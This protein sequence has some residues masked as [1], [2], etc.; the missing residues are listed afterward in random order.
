[1][2]LVKIILICFIIMANAFQLNAVANKKENSSKA[3]NEYILL[4]IMT[5]GDDSSKAALFRPGSICV[6]LSGNIFVLDSGNRRVVKFSPQ[7][8]FLQEFGRIGQGPGEFQEPWAMDLDLN[9]GLLYISDIISRRVE[10]YNIFGKHVKSIKV[11]FLHPSSPY[12]C[13]D[14]YGNIIM[15]RFT[16]KGFI[17]LFSSNFE[18]IISFGEFSNEKKS[19]LNY[20]ILADVSPN[21]E[22]W[23]AYRF[24]PVL[25]KYNKNHQ[26]IFSKEIINKDYNQFIKK[27]QSGQPT[28]KTSNGMRGSFIFCSSIVA[29]D[30]G[31][32]FIAIMDKVCHFNSKGEQTETFCLKENRWAKDNIL[33]DGMWIDNSNY[34]YVVNRM[35][36]MKVYKFSLNKIKNK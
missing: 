16:E 15:N 25:Q 21:D 28:F 11:A 35:F 3:I 4:P 8:N 2:H 14:N 1:M 32:C 6:D 19:M 33:A 31:G 5:I 23:V 26:L 17:A 9:K 36:S 22:L 24:R 27:Q 18:P 7:G 20:S 30:S 10:I 34:L 29:D 13:V 12:L